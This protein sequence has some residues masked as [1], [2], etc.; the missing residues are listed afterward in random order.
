MPTELPGAMVEPASKSSE[1]KVPL[2]ERKP[3][4]MKAPAPLKVPE[5]APLLLKLPSLV[6]TPVNVPVLPTTKVAPD[7]IDRG[8]SRLPVRAS[9]VVPCTLV[10][11]V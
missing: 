10:P 7:E 8:P 5:T 11:P 1:P 2:P 3:E 6:T 9:V 4:L